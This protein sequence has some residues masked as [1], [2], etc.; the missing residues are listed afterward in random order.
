MTNHTESAY[1]LTVYYD[2]HRGESVPLFAE[3]RRTIATVE[4]AKAI[5]A[6][7]P[8][9]MKLTATT[10]RSLANGDQGYIRGRVTLK[11]N[12]VNGGVNETG[13]KRLKAWVAKLD[14]EYTTARTS[15]AYATLT[16][17]LAAIG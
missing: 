6:E 8:K 5:V 16:D 2:C 12:G 15:N 1:R 4:E 14:T 3:I 10:L 13:V 17:A 11:A 7:L 9:S